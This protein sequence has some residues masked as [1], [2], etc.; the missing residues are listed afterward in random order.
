MTEIPPN[1]PLGASPSASPPGASAPGNAQL[2]EAAAVSLRLL[3][4]TVSKRTFEQ[5]RQTLPQSPDPRAALH[6]A[7][8]AEPVDEKLLLG[9]ALAVQREWIARGG[10]WRGPSF[11]FRAK[12]LLA[13]L[14]AQLVVTL[15]Y[16]L[17]FVAALLALK[18]RDADW[19]LYRLLTWGRELFG[20]R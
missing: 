17:L 3:A 16:L 9:K 7:V 4:G 1:A 18:Y 15:L 2:A 6:A 11:G 13:R 20:A 5:L 8:L 19:D 14:C 12:S 10:R